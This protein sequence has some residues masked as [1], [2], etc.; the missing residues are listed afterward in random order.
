MLFPS[1]VAVV[2][3]TPFVLAINVPLF[4]MPKFDR[5]RGGCGIA[6]PPTPIDAPNNVAAVV[7]PPPTGG[8]LSALPG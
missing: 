7:G 6:L 8:G 4:A 3:P 2:G 5:G 1:A